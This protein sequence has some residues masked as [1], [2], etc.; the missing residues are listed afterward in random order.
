MPPSTRDT[1]VDTPGEPCQSEAIRTDHIRLPVTHWA[2]MS[3]ESL[4]PGAL[5]WVSTP[6]PLTLHSSLGTCFLLILFPPAHSRGAQRRTWCFTGLSSERRPFSPLSTQQAV[7]PICALNVWLTLNRT[8]WFVIWVAPGT[9]RPQLNVASSEKTNG[10]PWSRPEP[11]PQELN[12]KWTGW[13]HS[14]ACYLVSV[15]ALAISILT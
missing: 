12:E 1:S 5:L 15:L 4:P 11:S 3:W 13:S 10:G 14:L 7:W 8:L 6:A 9:L 2:T